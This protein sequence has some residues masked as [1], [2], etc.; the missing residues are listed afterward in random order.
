MN[1][2][3]ETAKPQE[4]ESQAFTLQPSKGKSLE[5]LTKLRGKT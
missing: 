3:T 1:L 5:N 4:A 2:C